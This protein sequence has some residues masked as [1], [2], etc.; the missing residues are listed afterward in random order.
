MIDLEV[1]VRSHCYRSWSWF[2]SLLYWVWVLLLGTLESSLVYFRPFAE[3]G[4]VVV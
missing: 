2:S 1:L 4:L 3:A